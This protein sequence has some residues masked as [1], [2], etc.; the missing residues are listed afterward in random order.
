[1]AMAVQLGLTL[2]AVRGNVPLGTY[3]FLL[4]NSM[5]TINSSVDINATVAWYKQTK[6]SLVGV[7]IDQCYFYE[8]L[9]PLLKATRGSG[10]RVFGTMGSHNGPIYCPSVWGTATCGQQVLVPFLASP[11]LCCMRTHVCTVPFLAPTGKL[12]KS[13][14][15][16]GYAIRKI[17]PL[18]GIYYRRFLLHDGGPERSSRHIAPWYPPAAC[19]FHVRQYPRSHEAD[20]PAVH[21]HAHGWEPNACV[22]SDGVGWDQKGAVTVKT[23]CMSFFFFNIDILLH[24]DR[25][26]YILCVLIYLDNL[27]KITE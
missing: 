1:M 10:I 26:V 22:R 9:L 14:H 7:N 18:C 11:L 3:P 13:I 15:N 24:R 19:C 12:D 20:R 27:K 6:Q 4:H 8:A 21:V 25:L 5:P 23:T 17:S 2:L 16:L